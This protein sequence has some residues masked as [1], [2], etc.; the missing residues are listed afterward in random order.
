MKILRVAA[1]IYPAVVGGVGIHVHEMSKEQARLGHEVNV[2]TA[3]TD[4]EPD[5]ESTSGYNIRRFKPLMNLLGNSIMPNMF[6]DL[7]KNRHKHDIIHAHSHLYFSTNLC[8][9]LRKMGSSPLVITNHGLNSQTAPEWF[10]NIYTAT[11]AKLTFLAADKII[12]Y[13]ETGKNELI[14]LG[15]KSHKIE[16]IHNGIDTDHFVPAKKQCLDKK[17]LL[18]IGRY[19]NGKGVDNL[20]DAFNIL[21]SK[22][23]EASLTMVGRGPDKD[24]IIQ[25]IHDLELDKDITIKDFVPNSEIVQLYQNSSVFVLPSLE[26]GVPRTI[27]ESM[28]C[29]VPVVC[30]RLP[31]LVDIVE[32]SGF[33]VP[34]KDSQTLADRISEILSDISLAEGLG[35]NGRKNVVA[36]YSWKDTVKRT[37]QLYEGLI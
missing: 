11:G 5:N 28:S 7:F 4:S 9:L 27:L 20:I 10:Q 33:L 25:K 15:I 1:D 29:G 22:H 23:P 32:G 13:T 31:Q 2:Y 18:W 6:L 24:R 16:V 21:K 14:E 3:I 35:Q 36:N 37:I 12:C 17:R 34:I 30:T 19:A 8:A 26:E